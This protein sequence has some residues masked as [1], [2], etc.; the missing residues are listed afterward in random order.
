MLLKKKE[1]DCIDRNIEALETIANLLTAAASSTAN[2][3]L[4]CR[5]E[6][7]PAYTHDKQVNQHITASETTPNYSFDHSCHL[8]LIATSLGEEIVPPEFVSFLVEMHP[9]IVQQVHTPSGY[10]HLH[11]AVIKP[12]CAVG[13]SWSTG[14]MQLVGATGVKYENP[15]FIPDLKI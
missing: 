4:N 12:Y 2:I 14:S 9:G 8:Y 11:L 5:S 15:L 6:T 7:A 10:T 13:L 1:S 3:Y